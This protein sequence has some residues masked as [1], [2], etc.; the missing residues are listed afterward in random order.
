MV[1]EVLQNM[2]IFEKPYASCAIK[3]SHKNAANYTAKILRIYLNFCRFFFNF[4]IFSNFFRKIFFL[5]FCRFFQDFAGSYY[6]LYII[7]TF[8]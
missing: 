4:A 3:Y 5:N 7:D 1:D 6:L 8:H 2:T